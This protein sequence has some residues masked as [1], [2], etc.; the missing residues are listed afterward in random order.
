MRLNRKFVS[1]L[2]IL[3]LLPIGSLV[4]TNAQEPFYK[5]KQIRI[6]VGSTAG[7]FF[8][9]W[10]RLFAKHMGKYTAGGLGGGGQSRL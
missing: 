7:G 10:A 8:D 2:L 4:E 3:A 6:I 5:G 1:A 9:R